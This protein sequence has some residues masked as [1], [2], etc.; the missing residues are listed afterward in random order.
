MKSDHPPIKV[1]LVGDYLIFRIGLKLLIE[2]EANFKVVGETAS[3]SEAA[4]LIKR[5]N[6]DVILVNAPEIKSSE[7]QDFMN[8]WRGSIPVLVLTNSDGKKIFKTCFELGV[9]GLVSKEKNPEVLFKAIE[10]V[11]EGQLWFDRTLRGETIRQLMVEKQ[12]GSGKPEPGDAVELTE[13]EWE[14]LTQVCKGLKNKIIA[15]NLFISETTVRHH[16]TSIFEKLNV[17]SRLQLVVLAFRKNLVDIPP[18]TAET[19]HNLDYL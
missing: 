12:N 4:D 11:H 5:N 6:P 7:F 8:N 3:I 15:D 9:S 17:N 14:V 13:R 18:Q 10:Q 1:L 16:L 19:A 2:A